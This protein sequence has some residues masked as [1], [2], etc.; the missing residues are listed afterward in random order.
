MNRARAAVVAPGDRSAAR[1]SRWLALVCFV[2]GAAGLVFEMV[3]FHRSA[4][5]FGSS[6][7]ATSLVL[8]SFMGGLSI[9]SAIVGQIGHRIRRIAPHACCHRRPLIPFGMPDGAFLPRPM[10]V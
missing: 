5:V 8:S 1:D 9:G 6:V 2:S 7:W 4:L 10:P 3:W